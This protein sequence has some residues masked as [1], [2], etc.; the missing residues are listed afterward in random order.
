MFYPKRFLSADV[1]YVYIQFDLILQASNTINLCRVSHANLEWQ[2]MKCYPNLS[3]IETLFTE[4]TMLL[5]D[6]RY[7]V[8]HVPVLNSSTGIM[9]CKTFIGNSIE[10]CAYNDSDII[11]IVVSFYNRV[12][13]INSYFGAYRISI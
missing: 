8:L 7:L 1:L 6:S 11:N 4:F 10:S 12:N 13:R 2:N 5:L 3:P 9:F